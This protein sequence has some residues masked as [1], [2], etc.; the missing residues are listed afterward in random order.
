MEYRS[1]WRA[2]LAEEILA[3]LRHFGL[4]NPSLWDDGIVGI[5]RQAVLLVLQRSVFEHWSNDIC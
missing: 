3:L 2:L 1:P 4:N 5:V